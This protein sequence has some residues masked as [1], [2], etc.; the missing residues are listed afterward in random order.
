MFV[1]CCVMFGVCYVLFVCFMCRVLHVRN[2]VLFVLCC[3]L[4]VALLLLV[5]CCLWV[6]VRRYWL[7]G[8]PCL[9][10]AVYWLLIGMLVDGVC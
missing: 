9:L 7:F 8:V 3:L 5:I 2:C 1:G 4:T 10:L 6:A